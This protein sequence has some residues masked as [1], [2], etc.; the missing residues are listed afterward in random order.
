MYLRERVVRVWV[1]IWMKGRHT[2]T[3][4]SSYIHTHTHT[5]AKARK[6]RIDLHHSLYPKETIS[7]HLLIAESRFCSV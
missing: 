7:A 2:P 1:W 6:T 5:L 4:A 3:L